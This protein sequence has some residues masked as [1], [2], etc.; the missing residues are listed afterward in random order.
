MTIFAHN[1]DEILS[2]RTIGKMKNPYYGLRANGILDPVCEYED[3]TLW[4][5]YYM[6]WWRDSS[7]LEI[8]I[9]LGTATSTLLRE[10][11]RERE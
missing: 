9:R 8:D 7:K 2:A 1:R 11:E 4:I 3:V 10:R 5:G 6:R